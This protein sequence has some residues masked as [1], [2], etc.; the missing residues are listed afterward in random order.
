MDE[1]KKR[2]DDNQASKKKNNDEMRFLKIDK[3]E[4]TVEVE[5]LKDTI[6]QVSS[7]AVKPCTHYHASLT[8]ICM[9]QN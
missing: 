7:S 4:L 6:K 2:A 5:E 1:E 8:L 9:V 3:E